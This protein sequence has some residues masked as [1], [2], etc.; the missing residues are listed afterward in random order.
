[1]R[2][3]CGL[4]LLC[5]LTVGCG[6]VGVPAPIPSAPT[7][8]LPLGIN[9]GF[10]SPLPPDVVARYC[11]TTIRTPQVSVEGL[12]TYYQSIQSCPSMRTIVL[13]EGPDVALVQ[14]LAPLLHP[15]DFIELGNELELPPYELT[16]DQFAAFVASACVPYAITGG[17]YTLTADTRDRLLR[18]HTACPT[19][20]LGVHLYEDLT[21]A[22]VTWLGA[23]PAPVAVTEAGYPTRCDPTRAPQQLQWLR[24]RRAL[25]STIP[26]VTL[27]VVYQQP[28]GPSC[29]DLDTF[30]VIPETA[31]A[32]FPHP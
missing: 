30:G 20:L 15:G 24:D 2:R 29:S 23:L 19:A 10:H 11:G 22:D 5:V 28:T 31:D 13:V 6:P 32:L 7:R 26:T 3:L 27:L 1:M 17:V 12:L 4:A 18:A 25:F 9:A 14:A 16:V 21:T 8:I